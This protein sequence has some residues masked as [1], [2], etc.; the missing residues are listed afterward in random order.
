MSSLLSLAALVSCGTTSDPLNQGPVAGGVEGS[1]DE[2]VF[3][4]GSEDELEL[5]ENLSYE[6]L[7]GPTSPALAK[8]VDSLRTTRV[9][10]D[11][12][13]MA[14]TRVQQL[15]NGVPVFGGEAIVHLD[16]RG[17][18]F[19]VTDNLLA[20][21]RV[22]TT[23]DV[24]KAE[25]ME[26][27]AEELFGG[28]GQLSADPEASLWVLRHEG[29]DHLVWRVQLR[30]TLGQTGDTMPLYFIDAHTGELVW[31]YD[32]LQSA[33]CSGSTNYYGTVSFE[34]YTTGG[35]YYTEDAT[36]LLATFSYNNTTSSLSYVSSTSTTF[37][38]TQLTKNAVE[39]YYV[40]Q[41]TNSYFE[42]AHGRNGIDNA[43]GPAAVTTH[44]Y[45]FVTAATSYSRNYVNA[46]WD[47]T[48]MV[49]GDG[50]GSTASS[51]TA[52]DIGGHEL[53]HGV[54][55]YEANLTYSGESGHLNE[56]TSD[57][58]GAMVERS[59]LGEST[60]TW[61]IGED[62]WTP[63]TSGDALR[64][65]NDPGGRRLQLRLLHLVHRL[66]GRSLRL[67][68][69]QPGV[70]P[71][72]QGRHPPP[73]LVDRL[74]DGHRRGRRGGHLVPRAHELHDLVHELLRRPHRDAQRGAVALRLH[75][76]HPVQGRSGRLGG[77][78][79]RHVELRRRRQQL[80]LRHD[81]H[82]HRQLVQVQGLVLRPVVLGLLGHRHQPDRDAH[83]PLLRRL[84]PLPPEEVGQLLVVGRQLD[85]L[86]LDGVDQLLGHLG[87][88]P[89]ARLQLL[90][91]RQLQH[92]LVP[93]I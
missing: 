57:V 13:G 86:G 53:A 6:V 10:L 25:A 85:E 52:L 77:G 48:M 26:I 29:V 72:G 50:D 33:T 31:G 3:G 87:H 90:G 63:G 67:G 75:H 78:G 16:E 82:L 1:F 61:L 43:G 55:E 51:L 81:D 38:T 22:N 12:L 93:L 32:N 40:L 54:T 49:Y 7:Y 42:N 46:Y 8:G 41:K 20:N 19:T 66:R 47:G 56:S 15:V 30:R 60:D 74:G 18:L 65:M 88:L 34:C 89:C 44:G 70:L 14:H 68:R 91:Q 11:D 71:H 58:F 45:N 69:A 84:R 9:K 83:R 62:A 27:A 76:L 79:C 28:E 73:G 39:A 35:S 64:Y 21:V 2:P 23:P 92:D 17:K 36:Q 59:V 37:G 80:V 24:T 4:S 5:A